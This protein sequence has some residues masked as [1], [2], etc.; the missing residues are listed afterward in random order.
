MSTRLYTVAQARELDRRAIDALQ[1]SGF[2]LMQRAGN[3]AWR[4]LCARWPRCGKIAVLCG[5]GNN[6]GDGYVLACLARE[7]GLPVS[8]MALADPATPDA[9]RAR[10][11]WRETGGG[12]LST[13]QGLPAADVY[14]DAIFGTGLARPVAGLEAEAARYLNAAGRPVLALDVPSGICADTGRVLG[15]AVRAEATVT[16]IGR[17]RGLYTAAAPEYCGTL[18]LDRLGLPEE[19]LAEVPY[20]ARLLDRRR[21][22]SWLP[23]RARTAHK[24]DFGHVLAIGGDAGMG[25]AIRLCAEAA[26]RVGAGLVSCATRQENVPAINAARPEVMAHATTVV[27]EL[28]PLFDRASVIALGPGLGQS[29]WSRKLW[30]ASLDS[31]KAV[32][33]DADALNL[34]SAEAV[35]LPLDSVITPHPGEASRLLGCDT[36]RIAGD[37]FA[38]ARELAVRHR[39]VAVLKG[40]GTLIAHANGDVAV[41][42]W[43]NP[44]MA[45]GGMGDVL[46]GVI[47]GAMAQGLNA[48]RAARFGVAL[49]ALAGDAAARDGEA[50]TLASDLLAHLRRLRNGLVDD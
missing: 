20:D 14:V 19:A 1:I 9:R 44:G 49:H 40:A 8:V 2:E 42:P 45:S 50:G 27:A 36:T 32:V 35:V 43:G 4:V 48:W 10:D 3:A 38:A 13:G 33:A 11:A 46:A 31:G 39:C 37:R 30:R 28:A 6:G 29:D 17:K 15:I 41:C 21:M 24:G 5:A 7:A 47:A 22:S 16:F 34:L 18:I 12:E 25:G 26:L 23:P